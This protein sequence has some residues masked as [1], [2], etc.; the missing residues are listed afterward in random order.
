MNNIHFNNFRLLPPALSTSATR[1][2]FLKND[3]YRSRPSRNNR[4]I[5]AP[6]SNVSEKKTRPTVNVYVTHAFF[7]TTRFVYFISCKAYGYFLVYWAPLHWRSNGTHHEL[8]I[9][10][11]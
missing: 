5:S 4:Q 10:V 2:L 9:L 8:R 11:R 1:I 7:C 6:N 3:H